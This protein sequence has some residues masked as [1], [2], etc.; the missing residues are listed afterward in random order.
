MAIVYNLAT[1]ALQGD[2]KIHSQPEQG[3]TVTF[4]FPLSLS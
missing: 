4:T 3:I 1:Q 2:V